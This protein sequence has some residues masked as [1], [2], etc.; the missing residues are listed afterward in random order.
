MHFEQVHVSLTSQQGSCR[1]SDF[2][3]QR[4][5][6][7]FHVSSNCPVS[8]T[9]WHFLC[10][11]VENVTSTRLIERM[12]NSGAS[13][14]WCTDLNQDRSSSS[15]INLIFF[16]LSSLWTRKV[17]CGIF[18]CTIYIFLFIHS[19]FGFQV[20]S[21]FFFPELSFCRLDV[22][23][24]DEITKFFSPSFLGL[25]KRHL[26]FRIV[27]MTKHSS[28]HVYPWMLTVWEWCC[29]RVLPRV[30]IV[31]GWRF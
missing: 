20:F 2:R 8:H 14:G 6:E 24:Y 11:L 18:L 27:L 10:C 13:S 5:Q 17:L 21:P 7:Q 4:C 15:Y 3:I 9:T 31:R 12:V 29:F 28:S 26:I 19:S 22:E 23:H 1:I 30:L 25:T 16:L